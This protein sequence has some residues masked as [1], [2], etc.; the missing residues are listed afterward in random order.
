MLIL[1]LIGILLL[2]SVVASLPFYAVTR[3][4]RYLVFGWRLFLFALALILLIMAFYAAE[5]LL[6]VV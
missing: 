5:R 1:R 4:R 2:I 6:M 3:Q